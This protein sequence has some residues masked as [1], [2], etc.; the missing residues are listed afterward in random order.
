MGFPFFCFNHV[1]ICTLGV[2]MM[3]TLK[4][5]SHNPYMSVIMARV[6]LDFFFLIPLEISPVFDMTSDF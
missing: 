5:L 6:S 1:P 4:Y 3:I 2:F